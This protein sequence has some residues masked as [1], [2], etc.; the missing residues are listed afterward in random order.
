MDQ[1]GA[2][3]DGPHPLEEGADLGGAPQAA[4]DLPL[5]LRRWRLPAG[6]RARDL[7]VVVAVDVP[8]NVRELE[9]LALGARHRVAVLLEQPIEDHALDDRA[10]LVVGTALASRPLRDAAAVPARD[11]QA[12]A[13]E[14]EGH[15]LARRSLAVRE[16]A[17]EHGRHPHVALDRRGRRILGADGGE[18]GLQPGDR[19]E[20]DL[21]LA[22]GRQDLFDVAQEH[23]ARTDE[24]HPVDPQLTAVGVEQVRS[25]V[26]RDG[27][28]AGARAARDDQ[29]AGQLGP[30]GLVLLGLD[31]GH[32]V[33]HPAGALPLERREQRALTHDGEA[34]VVGGLGVEHLVVETDDLPTA[35]GQDVAAAQHTHPGDRGR[36]VERLGDGG[37]PVDHQRG[38]LGV[39]DAQ[40]A[41]VE[42]QSV[43][44]IQSS[45]AERGLTDVERGEPALGG[46][47]GDVAFEPGLVRPTT[48]HVG[49]GLGDRGRRGPH[50]FQPL[51]HRVEVGLLGDDLGVLS[52]WRHKWLRTTGSRRV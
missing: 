13:V 27:G 10:P 21:V 35:L 12:H 2:R 15:V 48:T 20:L 16:R 34:R 5:P 36:P 43:I 8:L 49:V 7:G 45:E 40:P 32:D 47:D 26:E 30:D 19:G 4:A 11:S 18:A 38:V 9:H 22:E 42:A 17:I 25:A 37:A 14:G 1:L 33:A 50:G 23:R 39:V 44:E 41:H 46:L 28:L 29:G 3:Q 52:G 51:V 31:R 6:E 24:E